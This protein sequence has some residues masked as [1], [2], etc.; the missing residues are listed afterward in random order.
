MLMYY[1]RTSPDL[2]L[3]VIY[4]G[5]TF[6]SIFACGKTGSD[7]NYFLEWNAALCLGAGLAYH[8]LRAQADFQN[9][10]S[11]FLPATLAVFVLL[12]LHSPRQPS[13]YIECRQAYEY[14]R[15]TPG[16][17]ILSEN[18]GAVVQAGKPLLVNDPFSW[19]NAVARGG[20]SDTELNNLIR[21]RQVDLVVLGS[22][23]EQLQDK[24]GGMRWTRP[25][26]DAINENYELT[27]GFNCE[28]ARFFYKP[29][30][31]P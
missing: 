29:R 21:S 17:N 16:T 7:N 3:P 10:L 1:A 28:C 23:V 13:S 9:A 11:A 19:S 15:A 14:V 5:L 18:V 20:W 12:N 6:L 27:T 2:W 24:Q 26:L 25:V 30:P 8:R 22:K 31:Q 4:L